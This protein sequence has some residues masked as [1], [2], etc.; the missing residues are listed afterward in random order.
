MKTVS[1]TGS[2]NGIGKAIIDLLQVT[3]YSVVEFDIDTDISIPL[4]TVQT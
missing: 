3:G 4:N 2:S 1:V